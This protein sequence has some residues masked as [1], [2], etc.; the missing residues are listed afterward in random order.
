MFLLLKQCF[1]IYENTSQKS[2]T[3][4]YNASMANKLSMK[5]YIKSKCLQVVACPAQLW[6]WPLICQA[7]SEL[8]GLKTFRSALID[9]FQLPK[10]FLDY[11]CGVN[12]RW[13]VIYWHCWH[14]GSMLL[15]PAH[16]HL[17]VHPSLHLIPSI[18]A[19]RQALGY[20]SPSSSTLLS[21]TSTSLHH[22]PS[23]SIKGSCMGSSYLLLWI[24]KHLLS[25]RQALGKMVTGAP[26]TA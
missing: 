16:H 3:G 6:W 4:P 17:P 25:G 23:F 14:F 2:L 8:K 7:A 15:P 19:S 9:F 12:H 10:P 18:N 26:H 21:C 22:S 20:R 24:C 5:S 13:R 11:I 1:L